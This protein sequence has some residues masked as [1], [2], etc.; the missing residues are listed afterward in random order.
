MELQKL[1]DNAY[2]TTAMVAKIRDENKWRRR[3]QK[4][5]FNLF[6]AVVTGKSDK[7]HIE[8]YHSNIIG[9]LLN[10]N[11][12]HDC[13]T[14]FLEHF[15][16]I[17]K[18]KPN[19]NRILEYN[20]ANVRIEREKPT[21]K[22]R[23][24]DIAIQGKD[25]M[26]FIENKV[27]SGELENQ[28][29]DYLEYAKTQ[30]NENVLGIFLTLNGEEPASIRETDWLNKTICLS[31]NDIILWLES[32]LNER[33]IN[34]HLH[35]KFALEQYIAIIKTLL[36]MNVEI[37]EIIAALKSDKVKMNSIVENFG[38]LS[39]SILVIIKEARDRF[40]FELQAELN[41][42]INNKKYEV[43]IVQGDYIALK[44]D[45]YGLGF[46]IRI[47][48]NENTNEYQYYNYGGNGFGGYGDGFSIG[49]VNVHTDIDTT[50]AILL[51]CAQN[52]K[53]WNSLID[54]AAKDILVKLSDKKI[55]W[56]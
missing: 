27:K 6:S 17:I 36:S 20:L 18:D 25:W 48:E 9:Y 14:I 24:I 22:G 34:Q 13:G 12:G 10:P 28:V 45:S 19:G 37:H 53:E 23:F 42:T 56:Q 32:C 29:K 16:A 40:Q 11:A 7:E 38:T 21:S 44:E 46:K 4:T 39:Q 30:Y 8:K 35:I 47:N 54:N 41:A 26:V 31:Y 15:L 51:R 2:I 3:L 1:V 52:E 33:Q 55:Q 50:N 5:G 43:E 49:D